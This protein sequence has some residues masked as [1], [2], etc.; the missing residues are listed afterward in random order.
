[1]KKLGFFLLFLC[2]LNL[3]AQNT[4]VTGRV[5]HAQTKEPIPFA[6][7]KFSNS[8]KGTITG[9]EGE[10]KLQTI[11]KVSYIH[12][13]FVGY[14][15][16]KVPVINGE[17]QKLQIL[18]EEDLEMLN[19]IELVEKKRKKEKSDSPAVKIMKKVWANKKK[20][21]NAHF[22]VLS[23]NEY[24]KTQ[25]DINNFGEDFKK[26]PIF[27]NFGFIFEYADTSE[28]NGKTTLPFLLNEALYKN[29]RDKSNNEKERVFIGNKIAGFENNKTI[30]SI[31][32]SMDINLDIYKNSVLLF[33]K[34]FASPI[35]AVGTLNYFYY[36][37]DS[38]NINGNKEYHLQYIPRRSHE[39]TF[40]GDIVVDSAHWAVKSI[41][42]RVDK[43]ANL[44]FI[45]DM[46]FEKKFAYNEEKKKWL[47]E[48]DKLTAD[49]QVLEFKDQFGLYMHRTIHYN[50]YQF[51]KHW[52]KSSID[53]LKE[54][55]FL[56]KRD[57]E[58]FVSSER[59]VELDQSEVGV[60]TMVDSVKNT[61][62]FRK[63]D[64]GIYTLSNGYFP[65]G[66]YKYDVGPIWNY[67]SA[68]SVEGNRFFIGGRT[69]LQNSWRW[70]TRHYLAYG[71]RDDKFKYYVDFHYLLNP[72]NYHRISFL[73]KRDYEILTEAGFYSLLNAG[74]IL[75]ADFSKKQRV[76]FVQAEKYKLFTNKDLNYHWRLEAAL[77]HTKLSEVGLLKFDFIPD[78]EPKSFRTTEGQFT[79]TYDDRPKF[80]NERST[81][82]NQLFIDNRIRGQLI[83]NF[84]FDD[85]FN[86]N[87][88]YQKVRLKLNFRTV[89]N[90]L[91]RNT[92]SIEG[93]KVF[94][95]VPYP[96]LFQAPG[97]PTIVYSEFKFALANN[98]EFLSDQYVQIMAQQ[99]FN[100]FFLNR[101]PLL[102]ELK[103]RE[104]VGIKGVYGTL[105]DYNS[106]Q[107]IDG[108]P[109]VAPDGKGYWEASIGI[110][111]ILRVLRLDYVWRLS[112]LEGHPN[113]GPKRGL[114]YRLEIRL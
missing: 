93:G 57:M 60:Y 24:E 71:D 75:S 73:H 70:H 99:Q 88:A 97:N 55:G 19:G 33:S 44:N 49:F 25:I 36:L 17:K 27:K 98:F 8:K 23:F 86:S 21:I 11:E 2:T 16:K 32:E 7:I 112:K 94:G 77:D 30:N 100:G 22:P 38:T 34:K 46:L 3:L 105:N 68:N 31:M 87:H 1:M 74:T 12:I 104:I 110:S 18:L 65:I 15:N 66:N 42:L 58:K 85:I 26:S 43:D 90:Q 45:S 37:K 28:I 41:S 72:K 47:I 6:N 20:N 63:I 52:S 69:A 89:F 84:G 96:L 107:T 106:N 76:N 111:N 79:L 95:K 10:F 91:G 54:Y 103:L 40:F 101:I 35:S 83:T 53:S 14:K 29:F 102:R 114:R 39:L 48:E 80:V 92:L 4:L 64:K 51:N 67:Y 56:N 5:L 78:G 81:L 50:D 9:V 108:I 59:P 82:R 62:Q 113:I 61:P 13:S 109:L